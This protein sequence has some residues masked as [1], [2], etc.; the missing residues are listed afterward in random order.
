MDTQELDIDA[1]P[2]PHHGHN[3]VSLNEP[4]KEME[5]A[6]AIPLWSEVMASVNKKQ[7]KKNKKVLATP[8]EHVSP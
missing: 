8:L 6:L 5:F 4:G 3:T 7:V 2:S 1:L